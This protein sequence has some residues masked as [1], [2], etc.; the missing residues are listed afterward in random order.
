MD[1][2]DVGRSPESI[3]TPSAVESNTA[4][5]VELSSAALRGDEVI[6]TPYGTVEL[7][8]NF[9]TDA[10]SDRLFDAMDL[11]RACQAY[12]WAT[13]LV[14]F[15]SWRD[16]QHEAYGSSDRATFAVLDT[17]LEKLGI[18]TANLTTPYIVNFERLTE[19]PIVIDYPAG[20]TAGA[21]LDAWQRPVADLG[22]TG[23]DGGAGGRY[24]FVGPDHDLDDVEADGAHV[25][26]SATNN[27]MVGLRLLDPDPEFAAGIRSALAIG[28]LGGP[29]ARTVFIAGLDRRWSS[30]PP[31]G[32]AYWA[33]LHRI[34]GDEPVRPQDRAWTAML[35]PLGIVRGA[36]F[37][38]DERQQRIL[39]DGAAMGELMAR[40]LQVNPRYTEPYWPGTHW[41]DSFDFTVRQMTDTQVEIDQ[42]ATWFYEALTSSEGMVNPTVGTGQVYM[43]TK[44][45]R[46]GNL[47]R[48]DHTYR[49]H[50]PADVPVGQ[51]WALTLYSED[52]RRPYDNGLGTARSCNLDSRLDDLRRNDDGSVDL[53]VGPAAPAGY[54]PNHMRTVGDDGWFVYFRLYAPLEPWFDKTFA[55]PDFERID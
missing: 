29:P 2:Q 10:S 45:D 26:H 47:F 39:L 32:L 28:P 6:V 41:Y 20:P 46:D 1:G 38:P 54:E 18:V 55:L 35:E 3:I 33:T 19:G 9:P 15:A 48:A 14:G 23:P 16:A 50:V 25:F 49:L 37:A 44:R 42:R 51:F 34:L 24:V 27:V 36:P 30:T 53:Y 5:A 11:Q 40:N 22:L 13:P 31:R 4:D 52:T 12:I 43:T 21:V 17:F 7:Q 8:H